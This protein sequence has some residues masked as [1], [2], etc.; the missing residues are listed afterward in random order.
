MLTLSSS[1][2]WGWILSVSS[3]GSRG[4]TVM[5]KGFAKTQQEMSWIKWHRPSFHQHSMAHIQFSTKKNEVSRP[6]S[7]LLSDKK[8]S[9]IPGIQWG[10]LTVSEPHLKR[11]VLRC[12]Q[13]LRAITFSFSTCAK[14]ARQ[15][16]EVLASNDSL[17]HCSIS[18]VKQA[19]PGYWLYWRACVSFWKLIFYLHAQ[20]FLGEMPSLLLFL[21]V[22]SHD[23]VDA[24]YAHSK[25]LASTVWRC[26]SRQGAG[27]QGTAIKTSLRGV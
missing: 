24:E 25:Y 20:I 11:A 22:N 6:T 21:S 27:I 2:I 7:P 5:R 9:A 3:C 26:H 10:F 14:V 12:W 8:T 23:Y 18:Y 17:Q 4:F 19:Y 1:N 15:D 13:R 16:N